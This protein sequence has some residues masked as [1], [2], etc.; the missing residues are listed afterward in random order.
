MLSRSSVACRSCLCEPPTVAA[1]RARAQH[2]AWL[3]LLFVSV[4]L[5]L[6]FSV[7]WMLRSWARSWPVGASSMEN[8]LMKASR[9]SGGQRSKEISAALSV[10]LYTEIYTICIHVFFS[11]LGGLGCAALTHYSHLRT[12]T[13][14]SSWFHLSVCLKEKSIR[15]SAR[16]SYSLIL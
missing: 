16:I 15:N 11:K 4:A 14:L 7:D 10:T 8:C 2:A 1:A 5:R 13:W 12:P 9:A 6:Q 3:L